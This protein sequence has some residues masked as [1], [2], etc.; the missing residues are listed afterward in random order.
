MFPR[1]IKANIVI[2]LAVLLIAA[3]L[4]IDFIMTIMVQRE[5][6]QSESSK[7]R[8]VLSMIEMHT[9]L[10]MD[11]GAVVFEWKDKNSFEQMLLSNGFS[12]MVVVDKSGSEVF[13]AGRNHGIRDPLV[14]LTRQ[15]IGSGEQQVE[16]TGK[17]WG[18]FWT[19]GRE[20]LFAAPLFRGGS[21][22]AGAGLVLVLEGVYQNL[23]YVQR[24][25]FIY[26]LINMVVL[27]LAGLYRL[28]KVYLHPL[29]RLVKR[30]EE[31]ADENEEIFFS[32]RQEDDELRK[33][34]AALNRMLMRISAD[35]E[36]LRS[37]VMSLE[38]ANLDLKQAQSEIVRAEKLASIGR[39]SSGI[40]HEIGN[41]IGIVIGYLD[42]LKQ[43]N[44]S[45]EKQI[46]YIERAEAEVN[47]IN[48]IIRQLL[49]LSR[50]A[51]KAPA[52]VS[53]HEILQ[54]MTQ[55]LKSQP[56][57]SGVTLN[58]AFEAESDRVFADADQLRQVFL[59]LIINAADAISAV[60]DKGDGTL[61][62]QTTRLSASDGDAQKGGETL[63]I[64]FMD[65]GAGI[66]QEHI[67]NIF[68]P[69]Y[70]T[71][72]PG[73]GTGLGLSVSFMIVEGLG[74]SIKASSEVGR[75]TTMTLFLPLSAPNTPNELAGCHDKK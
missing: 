23:R 35:R 67:V 55:V 28:S 41:P 11:S 37:T 48:R 5:L 22:Y 59:N 8:L 69:F 66:S 45:K 18:V 2:T 16:Y 52:I 19:G 26:V 39:L 64:M 57:M 13:S 72:E 31:Y 9:D 3:M 74:G 68:D 34:S 44:L 25:L 65:N 51:Q 62:I 40:A 17:T 49:D 4:L 58:L 50:P 54:D 1:G 47:R 12:L 63:K 7:G 14:E 75:G 33:L 42:L 60:Q 71:K 32:V 53:A 6:I 15:A 36:K 56:L 27:T 61:K 10:A 24:V 21:I 70:T 30:A 38:R 73:K 43:Q 20:I 46:E 29:L